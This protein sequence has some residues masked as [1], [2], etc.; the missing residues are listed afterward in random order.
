MKVHELLDAPEKWTQ[1][2]YAKNAQG[3][4]VEYCEPEAVCWCLEGAMMR[5]YGADFIKKLATVETHLSS[6]I[7][8][9]NDQPSRTFEQVRAIALEL[10]I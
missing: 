2:A 6:E 7:T 4:R 1:A 3:E 8:H 9:W 10:D 5:C